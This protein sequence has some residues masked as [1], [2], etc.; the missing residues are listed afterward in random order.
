MKRGRGWA[1]FGIVF[2]SLLLTASFHFKL[3]SSSET[4]YEELI[5]SAVAQTIRNAIA[6][7]V[8]NF[9]EPVAVEQRVI[10]QENLIAFTDQI[11][12][13]RGETV[14]LFVR[15]DRSIE[16]T[17]STGFET[18]QQFETRPIDAELVR[19]GLDPVTL[20]SV[21]GFDPNLFQVIEI[22]TIDL[23]RGWSQIKL[24]VG[25]ETRRIP[26]LVE[27]E[28]SGAKVLFVESTYTLMAYNSAPGFRTAYSNPKNLTGQFSRPSAYP[29][30]YEISKVGGA[31]QPACSDHLINADLRLKALLADQN[32]EIDTI[33]DESLASHGIPDGYDLVV[34][35]AH[36]EYWPTEMYRQI[37]KFVSEGGSLLNFGGNTAWRN[38]ENSG[39][40]YYLFWG[41]GQLNSMKTQFIQR[42]LGAY[43]DMRGYGTSS[44]F[45][46]TQEITDLA[47]DLAPE[48]RFGFDSEIRCSQTINGMSGTETDK[49]FAGAEHFAVI[50][51]GENPNNGGA[52]IVFKEVPGGGYILN[53]G[54]TGTWRGI[55]DPTVNDILREFFAKSGIV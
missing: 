42:Y 48:T 43:Y 13:A 51:R 27:A 28:R 33:S 50:A 35:G 52:Q 32:V 36:V 29:L 39:E 5:R 54:S 25:E 53:F 40:G 12:Y 30:D 19:A 37:E 17:L 23:A 10:Y 14:Q 4:P 46:A 15:T 2:I 26:F 1:I 45:V 3:F 9:D 11:A 44:G 7:D 20:N 6:L 24:D 16:I 8:N 34:L 41:N 21:T 18:G 55:H 38:V 22:P 31:T 47:P 49:L